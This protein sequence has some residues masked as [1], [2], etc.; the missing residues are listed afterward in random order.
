MDVD[1]ANNPPSS[2]MIDGDKYKDF[3]LQ[4]FK[5][6][7]ETAVLIIGTFLAVLVIV[8]QCCR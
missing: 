3:N 8:S 2:T 5:V 1:K 6:E 4:T 7:L